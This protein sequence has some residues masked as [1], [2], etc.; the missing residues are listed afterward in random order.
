M[1]DTLVTAKTEESAPVEFSY[2]FGETLEQM[3]E[4]FGV[5]VVT[6][7]ALRGLTVA[8]QGHARGLIKQGKSEDEIKAAMAEW[9]PGAPRVTK[10][11][12]D[13]VREQLASLSPEARAQ[14]LREYKAEAKRG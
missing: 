5:D 3:S 14:L 9:K 4:R 8:V 13:K 2:T 11:A 10:S 7:F 12:E 6:S 1:S